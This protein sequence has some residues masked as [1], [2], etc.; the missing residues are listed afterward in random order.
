MKDRLKQRYKNRGN[1]FTEHFLTFNG[2]FSQAKMRL[3]IIKGKT[4]FRLRKMLGQKGE[5]A[6][7]AVESATDS[8]FRL[9]R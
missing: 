1:F 3:A 6:V 2:D 9:M 4:Q 7:K 8:I 5:Y